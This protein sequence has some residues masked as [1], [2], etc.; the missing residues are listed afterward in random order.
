MTCPEHADHPDPHTQSD[1]RCA[2]S[3][4]P[5]AGSLHQLCP[6]PHAGPGTPVPPAVP[7]REGS[8]LAAVADVPVGG[9][10]VLADRDVVITQPVP[11]TFKAFT[12]LH[13]PGLH[14]QRG[15]QRHHQLPLPRQP[16]RSGRR[17]GHSRPSHHTAA[18]KTVA[19]QDNAVVLS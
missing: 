8:V 14:G 4:L 13:P 5:A 17:L 6:R 12:D 3:R 16:L 11:A 15:G 2:L 19:V 9:G 10:V 7:A 1:L 18:R